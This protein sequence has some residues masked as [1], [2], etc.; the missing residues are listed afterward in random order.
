MGKYAKSQERR[1]RWSELRSYCKV[2]MK[3]SPC[4]APAW[5]QLDNGTWVCGRH[6]PEKKKRPA[7]APVNLQCQAIRVDG[8]PCPNKGHMWK[9]FNRSRY[10]LC[11]VHLHHPHRTEPEK[12]RK[13]DGEKMVTIKIRLKRKL[14]GNLLRSLAELRDLEPAN[15]VT[16]LIEAIKLVEKT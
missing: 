2:E 10:W 16:S 7:D 11:G 8:C 14:V 4:R 15:Y 6:H 1:D 13:Q 9:I 12:L 5:K 3:G